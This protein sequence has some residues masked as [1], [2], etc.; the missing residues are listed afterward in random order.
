MSCNTFSSFPLVFCL[1]P[2][3]SRVLPI[4]RHCPYP[5]RCLEILGI[6]PVV[7]WFVLGLQCQSCCSKI[8]V[9]EKKGLLDTPGFTCMVGFLF[10]TFI[11]LRKGRVW[12]LP[13]MSPFAYKLFSHHVKLRGTQGK[14]QYTHPQLTKTENEKMT[15][16]F[17]FYSLVGITP[18]NNW[19]NQSV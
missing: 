1:L 12:C 16:L 3:P 14:L 2:L 11:P 4:F 7:L 13:V 17:A 9:I 8:H 18:S 19:F 6:V 5:F 10:N 15:M